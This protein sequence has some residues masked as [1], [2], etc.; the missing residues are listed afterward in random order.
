MTGFFAI[1]PIYA[2]PAQQPLVTCGWKGRVFC[3]WPLS[4]PLSNF[5]GVY[6]YSRLINSM[7]YAVYVGQSDDVGRRVR[8]HA[9]DDPQILRSSHHIQCLTVNDG[10]WVR[11]QI[12][13]DMI[14]DYNP[15]M[16][17]IHR[18]EPAAREIATI[19]PDRCGSV[20]GPFFR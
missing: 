3:I 17:T 8:E 6:I 1:P 2:F 7:H 12:E 15:P 13:K 14:A 16:N 5:S 20:L 9:R 18:T 11:R 4:Q 10:E 19:V